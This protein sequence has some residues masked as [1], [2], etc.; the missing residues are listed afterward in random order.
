VLCFRRTVP[1]TCVAVLSDLVPSHGPGPG[2]FAYELVDRADW[3]FIDA[4]S[5]WCYAFHYLPLSG[6]GLAVGPICVYVCVS[7]FV[8]PDNDY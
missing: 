8:C 5:S 6:P 2:A 1:G 7:V 4:G 3:I